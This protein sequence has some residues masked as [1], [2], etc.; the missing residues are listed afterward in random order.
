MY[1]YIA[2]SVFWV[3]LVRIL[4]I[5]RL[6]YVVSCMSVICGTCLWVFDDL[7]SES[8]HRY[9]ARNDDSMSFRLSRY[10]VVEKLDLIDSNWVTSKSDRRRCTSTPT[11]E[12]YSGLDVLAPSTA[13][14]KQ[15]LF[16]EV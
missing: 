9:I 10:V 12:P 13:A 4:C 7:N 11:P 2:C 8:I 3:Y 6:V 1:L 15:H 16:V 5:L 14:V